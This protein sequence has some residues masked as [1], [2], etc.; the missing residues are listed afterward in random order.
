MQTFPVLVT[1]LGMN[2]VFFMSVG[3]SIAGAL[4]TFFWI[5]ITKDKSMFELETLFA[6][7]QRVEKARGLDLFDNKTILETEKKE[8]IECH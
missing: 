4:F 1:I 6:P 7:K 5:P 8:K 2:G 3:T